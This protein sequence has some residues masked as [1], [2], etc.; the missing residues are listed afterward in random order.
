MLQRQ[1][2]APQDGRALPQVPWET[3]PHYQ[4]PGAGLGHQRQ[5]PLHKG[6]L[7]KETGHGDQKLQR[8]V[9]GREL[10]LLRPET[11]LLLPKGAGWQQRD[12]AVPGQAVP[13]RPAAWARLL[14]EAPQA[15]L[16]PH[17]THLP[18]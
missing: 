3:S 6:S 7:E 15:G 11:Q 17:P 1:R 2:R 14:P 13:G 8:V 4:C 18:A 16:R 9:L 10:P 12:K 5:H